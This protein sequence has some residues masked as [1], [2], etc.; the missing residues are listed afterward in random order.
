VLPDEQAINLPVRV[1]RSLDDRLTDVVYQLR[2]EGVRSTKAEVAEMLL[3][4]LPATVDEAFRKRLV[5]FRTHA[6][7]ALRI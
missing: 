4:E 7:R 6:P 3:Y 5:D 2:R 1:R